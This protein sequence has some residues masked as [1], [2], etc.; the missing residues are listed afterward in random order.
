MI[1]Y[2][3]LWNLNDC[4]FNSKHF[5]L[6]K[7]FLLL[8]C[9]KKWI[10]GSSCWNSV[11]ISSFRKQVL[12]FIRA[13]ETR[14]QNTLSSF[15]SYGNEIE[16]AHQYILHSPYQYNEKMTLLDRIRSINGRILKLRDEVTDP[17]LFFVSVNLSNLRNVKIL[18]IME[19]KSLMPSL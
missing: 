3:L 13:V 14:S 16:C 7:T 12:R 6:R 2:L 18:N 11:K 8:M 17:T 15:Y 9:R 10:N 1:T 19:I 5:F 4:T